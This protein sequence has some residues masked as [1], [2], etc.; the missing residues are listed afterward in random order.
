MKIGIQ[1]H[2]RIETIKANWITGFRKVIK[3]AGKKK[4]K[5][6]V[7]TRVVYQSDYAKW[8]RLKVG[9]RWRK[10]F[11]WCPWA[12]GFL[13]VHACTFLVALSLCFH[14]MAFW[15]GGASTSSR[16]TT[17]GKPQAPMGA[18]ILVFAIE[19]KDWFRENKLPPSHA[20]LRSVTGM[21]IDNDS[22]EW[23]LGL[24]SHCELEADWSTIPRCQPCTICHKCT[25]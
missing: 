15:I 4:K 20:L 2:L 1:N 3:I 19:K 14:S 25:H 11:K 24:C 17:N 23:V 7:S 22:D 9:P 10:P 16:T 5:K 12:L 21:G 6:Q 13:R 18:R 8:V